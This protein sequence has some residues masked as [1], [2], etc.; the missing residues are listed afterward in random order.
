M[1]LRIIYNYLFGYVS[2][3]VEGCFLERFINISVSKKIFLLNMKR[4]KSTI[5]YANISLEDFKRI[6]EVAR[7]TR[8]RI[9][10]K[11]KGGLPFIFNR[12]RK[13][14]VFLLLLIIIFLGILTSSRFVWN[15]EITGTERINNQELIKEM[16]DCGLKVGSR[17]SN[18]NIVQVINEVR[19]NHEDIAWL[20]I[21]LKGTNAIVEVVE[22]AEKPKIVDINDYCNIISDKEGVITKI[23]VQNG[24]AQ[25]NIGDVI[26]KGD[27][28]VG[29]YVEG[30]YTGVRNVHAR[31]DI[32][33]KV[34]YSK[35]Q[36][37]YY[38]QT[39]QKETGN[40]ES[41]YSI[42][43]KNFQINLFK[44]ISKFEK[45]DTI[46]NSKKVQI[47]SNFYLPIELTKIINNEIIDEEKV[48]TKEELE[49]I[50]KEELSEQILKEFEDVPTIVNEQFNVRAE[51]EYIEC[52]LIYEVL[53]N[54][55]TEEK[56][57][58]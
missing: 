35:K 4:E 50:A 1:L 19:M 41:K 28:L 30:Q 34:W 47:F 56:I 23:S 45:Y 18:V 48:Y 42:K 57:V 5:L 16:E 11:K 8:S 2:I 55:G 46:Y 38:V 54:V 31:A 37:F 9:Y 26:R 24:T 15:I 14:K 10:I 44:S 32:Q 40:S 21:E 13:R 39:K 12:Y 36:K 25:V 17:K 58:Y 53:E 49:K 52:E 33:A 3:M 51:A 7:K 27:V 6:K 20:G 29:G 22:S 43:F